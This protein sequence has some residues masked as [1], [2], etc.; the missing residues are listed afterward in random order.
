MRAGA[1]IRSNTVYQI[2]QHLMHSLI[3][4]KNRSE[5]CLALFM[6]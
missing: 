2:A 3:L 4:S 1:V 6:L 5:F